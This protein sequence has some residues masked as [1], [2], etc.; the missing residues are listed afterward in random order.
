MVEASAQQPLRIGE[1]AARTGVGPRLLRHYENEGVLPAQRSSAGQRLFPPAAVEQV[2]FI[3]ELLGAGLPLRA[4]RE[5]VGCIHEPGRVEPCAVPVLVEHLQEY[6][7]KI[8]AL[9]STRASLRGLIEASA[10]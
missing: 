1:L 8:A 6:D 5:L 2:R 9:T 10:R 7:R 4:I 3:R